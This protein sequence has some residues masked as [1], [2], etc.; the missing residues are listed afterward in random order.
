MPLPARASAAST[1]TNVVVVVTLCLG[2]PCPAEAQTL[3]VISVMRV[4]DG[5]TMPL[6]AAGL[7][8][9]YDGQSAR[10]DWCAPKE[11]K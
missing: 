4:Y 6:L 10:P 5:D 7:A 9:P 11:S 2:L 1:M 8:V 3:P